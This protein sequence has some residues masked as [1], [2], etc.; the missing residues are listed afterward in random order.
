MEPYAYYVDG[1]K[2]AGV[3]L[4]AAGEVRWAWSKGKDSFDNLLWVPRLMVSTERDLKA[5][6]LREGEV[7][8]FL[9]AK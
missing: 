7:G 1:V 9:V 8:G 6:E 4:G 5:G 3:Y 2:Q